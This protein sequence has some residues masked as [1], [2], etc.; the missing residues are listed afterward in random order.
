MAFLNKYESICTS[1][2]LDIFSVPPT[3]VS[4]ESGQI[5]VYRPISNISPDSTIEFQISNNGDEY[6]HPSYTML[7]VFVKVIKNDGSNLT[8]NDNAAPINNWLHSMFSQVDIILNQRNISP[9][10]SHYHYKA[11]I[12]TL[13]NYGNLN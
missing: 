10:A 9:P 2:E 7:Q 4:I 5:K 11:Y 13:L 6:I 3:Q 1:S 12:E 8:E